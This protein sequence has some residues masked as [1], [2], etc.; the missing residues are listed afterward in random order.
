MTHAPRWLERH[1]VWLYL[2]AIGV[3]LALGSGLHT[4]G[5]RLDHVVLP[6]VGLL[7]FTTFTQ[8]PLAH[9]PRAAR[10]LRFLAA[11]LVANFIVVPLVVWALIA[12]ANPEPL[13]VLG[14]VLVLVVPC[15]DWF[16]TFSHLAGGDTLRAV[17]ITPYLLLI[18]LLLLPVYVWM[19]AGQD[20][21]VLVLSSAVVWSFVGLIVVPLV[22]AA[23]VE[24]VAERHVSAQ[25]VVP[26]LSRAPVPLLALVVFLI[27]SSQM[28]VVVDQVDLL[29]LLAAVFVSY[30]VLAAGVGGLTAKAFGL[31]APQ[32]RTVIVSAGTRN[33]FVVLPIA[34]ALPDGAAVVTVVVVFQSLVELLGM[35]AYVALVPRLVR[36]PRHGAPDSRLPG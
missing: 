7:I 4:L 32:A 11:V 15:T 23:V 5:Q 34:L 19:I 29:P 22:L 30:L 21:G 14:I 28:S 24:R 6:V 25:R 26:G 9:L 3:G 8:V 1:Q 13:A 33:S 36:P 27:A 20:V 18:Q 16:V 10:D 31:G 2:A 12:V 35:V 17:A